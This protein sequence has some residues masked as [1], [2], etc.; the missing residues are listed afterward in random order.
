MKDWYLRQSPRDRLIVI[1]VGALVALGLLW[2]VLWYPVSSRIEVRRGAIASK[3]ETLEFM[4]RAEAEIAA[5]GGVGAGQGA[6]RASDEAP[7]LLVDRLIREAGVPPPDRVEPAGDAGAR[8]QFS[9]VE[10]DALV[11]VLAELELYGLT[12]TNMTLTRRRPGIVSARFNVER[13]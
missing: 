1:A 9:E 5:A 2:A 13:G 6:A 12:V 4:R 10:F 11:P 3:T 7:Y 8:V